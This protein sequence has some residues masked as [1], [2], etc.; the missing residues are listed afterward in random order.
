MIRALYTAASGM[1]A[2]QANIDN[3]AHNLANANT[4]GF[5]KSR[6]EFADLVYDQTRVPGAPTSTTGEAPIGIETGLGTR[7]VGTARDFGRGN[8]RSTSGPL[9]LAIEGEGFFQIQMP[10]GETGYT[11]TGSFH[12]N[13][14][15]ALVTSEGFVVEPQISI[16]ADA[17]A[18]TISKT[19]IVSGLLPGQS[20]SQQIGTLEL[21]TFQNP[22][23]LR[24]AGG[25]IFMPTTA[26]GDAQ[27]G[28]PGEE[29]RGMVAQGFIED[30]NVSVVEEMV[31]M[32][33]GQRAYE[34]N[35]KV[36][37]AADEMLSQV[38]TIVR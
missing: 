22:A 23:G 5:K 31:N 19:G 12:L 17:T 21:A 14:E 2:Q 29:S 8:L 4:A 9:D 36:I 38:N 16:P 26:S 37:K 32:I 34:A 35:S 1:T 18:I 3:V 27:V 6:V 15:G 33:L 11:R 7:V 24:A 10:S 20:S 13:G 25:N 28:A 30:S